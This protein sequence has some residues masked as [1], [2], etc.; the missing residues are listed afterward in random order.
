MT[1][2][3]RIGGGTI[4][5]GDPPQDRHDHPHCGLDAAGTARRLIDFSHEC[6][7]IELDES[8]RATGLVQLDRLLAELVAAEKARLASAANWVL[9]LEP[10]PPIRGHAEALRAMFR[11]FFLNAV[12]SFP[13]GTGTITISTRTNAQNWLSV[14]IL[15]DGSG[16]EDEALQ[17]AFEPFYSTKPDHGGIGLAIA[18]SIWRRH[19]GTISLESLP[20]QGT[21]VR[22]SA[23]GL[24]T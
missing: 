19:R 6:T 10:V 24:E 11:Q 22:L 21:V 20:E 12:E 14:E 23:A 1:T 5:S 8:G 17:R 16:M 13:Q 7:A 3:H 9:K 2:L 4:S 15:D 18:R